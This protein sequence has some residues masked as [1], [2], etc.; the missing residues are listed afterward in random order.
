MDLKPPSSMDELDEVSVMLSSILT[1]PRSSCA[2]LGA[3]IREKKKRG[4][5]RK[6]ER[7]PHLTF[8]VVDLKPPSSMDE[9][10]EVAEMSLLRRGCCC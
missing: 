3:W 7:V 6:V 2:S 9:L 5:R 4:K 8:N 1:L 10:D